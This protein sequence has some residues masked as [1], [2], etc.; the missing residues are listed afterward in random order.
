VQAFGLPEFRRAS[1]K[2]KDPDEAARLARAYLTE[3]DEL[4]RKLDSASERVRVFG[5]LSDREPTHLDAEIAGNVDALPADQKQKTIRAGSVRGAGREMLAHEASAAFIEV[6]QDA[7]YALRDSMGEG[8]YPDE[9]ERQ[10]VQVGAR[11]ALHQKKGKVLREALAIEPT[12]NAVI[13]L[14][15]LLETY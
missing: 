8:Y 13:G 14:R 10:N 5:D 3:L 15:N 4:A 12:A 2:T 11:I 1:M 6:G 9:Q 7:G